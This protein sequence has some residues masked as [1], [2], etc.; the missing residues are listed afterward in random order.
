LL[1]LTPLHDHRRYE[2]PGEPGEIS[3]AIH[4]ARLASSYPKCQACPHRR[5]IGSLFPPQVITRERASSSPPGTGDL[6]RTD[7]G[8]RSLSV[9]RLGRHE[10]ITWAAALAALLWDDVVRGP[11]AAPTAG[12]R[13]PIAYASGSVPVIVIGYDERPAAPDVMLGLVSGLERMS[14]RVIDIGLTTEPCLRFSVNHLNADAGV[15][16]TGAGCDPAWIGFDVFRKHGLPADPA[17]LDRWRETQRGPVS[18][19]SRTAGSASAYS[20]GD[21]YEANLGNRFHALRPLHVVCGATSPNLLARLERLFARLPGRLHPVSLPTRRRD[22]ADPQDTDVRRTGTIVRDR[23]AHLGV[24]ID[25][26]AAACSFLD[27]RGEL[28]DSLALS[29][30]LIAEA[31]REHGSGAVILG[32]ELWDDLA[33]LATSRGGRP[34]LVAAAD[35]AARLMFEQGLLAI[36]GDQRW[37]FG[38]TVPV[39]DAI[40]SL[41]AVMQL[42]SRSDAEF[43]RVASS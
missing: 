40:V 37:W 36:G 1:V 4:L 17:F 7:H 33:P 43:S 21:A 28:V 29:A 38:E 34:V 18:R 10:A 11:L 9:N 13:E 42:L 35:R 39:C 14:C 26:D 31:L 22:L 32:T 8:F 5:D 24:V 2:C 25:D 16:I 23:E 19:P 6:I 20:A 15:M 41:A 27:E 30:Q 12:E 3:R